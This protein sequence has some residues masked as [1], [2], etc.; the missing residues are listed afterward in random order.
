MATRCDSS[1]QLSTAFAVRRGTGCFEGRD[2][3][4]Y[5]GVLASYTHLHASGAPSWARGLVRQA[6]AHRQAREGEGRAG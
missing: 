6:R 3:L 2:G 1:A 5:K 4:V